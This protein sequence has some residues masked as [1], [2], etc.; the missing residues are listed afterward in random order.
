M[1]LP[2]AATAA[3]ATAAAATAAAATAAAECL[4]HHFAQ[5]CLTANLYKQN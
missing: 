3:A 1:V 4:G 2:A 5:W